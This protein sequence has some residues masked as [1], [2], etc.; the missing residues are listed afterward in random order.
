MSDR[1]YSDTQAWRDSRLW[2]AAFPDLTEGAVRLLLLGPGHRDPNRQ[3]S[4]EIQH[5]LS[6]VGF[7][8]VSQLADL[9]VDS[10]EV[11]REASEVSIIVALPMSV[12]S[13]SEVLDL[14][15]VD[16]RPASPGAESVRS[17]LVVILPTIHER[18]YFAQVLAELECD[19][20]T[21]DVDRLPFDP[22]ACAK[23]G[24][25][26][27]L[28]LERNTRARRSLRAA[29]RRTAQTDPDHASAQARAA[30]ELPDAGRGLP[31]I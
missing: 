6:R 26:L 31:L 17:K 16:D 23:L 15:I 7:S 29:R 10:S 8:V 18:G 19:L 21:F 2:S 24:E 28:H 27:L 13:A 11:R 1:W 20:K 14:L 12:G 3:V 30:A 9:D 25:A 4:S 5:F 22:K